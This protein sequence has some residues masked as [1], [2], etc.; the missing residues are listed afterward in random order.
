MVSI[1]EYFEHS[2]RPAQTPPAAHQAVARVRPRQRVEQAE[3]GAEQGGVERAV[4]Q[5]PDCRG[6]PEDRRD[7][8]GYT[9][10]NPAWWLATTQPI[11]QTR[12]CDQANN[13]M[14]GRRTAI[15][16]SVPSRWAAAQESHQLA[17]G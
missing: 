16:A 5:D 9:A 2:A 11:R 1:A 10:Q 15:G 7:V 8:Q 17:G 6:D 4:R 14:K 3:R 12:N 13:R